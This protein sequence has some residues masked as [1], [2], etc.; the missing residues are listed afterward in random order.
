[1]FYIL[2]SNFNLKLIQLIEHIILDEFKSCDI[3]PTWNIIRDNLILSLEQNCNSYEELEAIQDSLTSPFKTISS[4]QFRISHIH[5]SQSINLFDDL[6][7]IIIKFLNIH[8]QIKRFNEYDPINGIIIASYLVTLPNFMTVT[9]ELQSKIIQII[10]DPFDNS[11]SVAEMNSS[12][13]GLTLVLS[14]FNSLSERVKNKIDNLIIDLILSNTNQI[15]LR[16]NIIDSLVWPYCIVTSKLSTIPKIMMTLCNKPEYQ[17]C[18]FRIIQLLL[19]FIYQDFKI[20]KLFNG[21]FFEY[22]ISCDKCLNQHEDFSQKEF[23]VMLNVSKMKI[24]D[25]IRSNFIPVLREI[26]RLV[27]SQNSDIRQKVASSL[28]AIFNHAPI[29]C[30]NESWLELFMDNDIK[31]RITL[32]SNLKNIMNSIDNLEL[33]ARVQELC[34]KQL[35]NAQSIALDNPDMPTQKVVL[36][37]ITNLGLSKFTSETTLLHCFRMMILFMMD[38]RSFL[39]REASYSAT[40][41]CSKHNLTPMK[42]FNMHKKTILKLMVSM[43]T[44]SYLEYEIMLT[45]SWSAVVKMFG[46]CRIQS[47]LNKNYKDIV[48]MMVPYCI[49]VT[50]L[51]IFTILYNFL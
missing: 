22:R 18:N 25:E 9:N 4:I 42:L 10:T 8:T 17:M 44:A 30:D 50:K 32:A 3:S 38:S 19:C 34:L 51:H 48:S 5:T 33:Q 37:T 40:E 49:K 7:L 6:N 31:V 21:Q 36:N 43:S 35:L 16:I 23:A 14:N 2:A 11:K 12:I 13:Q 24:S 41:I 20:Y 47:F 29:V 1:M 39:V 15:E 46:V 45:R 28:H 26:L 27:K